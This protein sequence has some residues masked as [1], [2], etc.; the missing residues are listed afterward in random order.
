MA[1]IQRQSR[2]RCT[3]SNRGCSSVFNIYAVFALHLEE[4]GFAPVQCTYEGCD[5][6]VNK[7]DLVSHQRSCEFRSVT[8]DDCRETIRQREYTNHNCVLRRELA[9]VTRML[10]DVQARQVNTYICEIYPAPKLFT[11]QHC[12]HCEAAWRST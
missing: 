2:L 9:E 12:C 11:Y 4:C 1:H 8:C 5:A 7:Q 3:H 10:R 6:T